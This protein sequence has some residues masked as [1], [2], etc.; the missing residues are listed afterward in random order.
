MPRRA[1]LLR[2][3]GPV[4]TQPNQRWAMD[5]MHDTLARG[6]AIRIFTLVDVCTRECVA[7]HVTRQFRGTDIAQVLSEAD[8]ARGGLPTVVQCGRWSSAPVNSLRP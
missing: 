7:V 3:G 2:V 1:V 4:V 8:T 5:F 6:R